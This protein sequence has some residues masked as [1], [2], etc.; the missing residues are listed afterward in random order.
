MLPERW[1]GVE[2]QK[3][4]FD[5]ENRRVQLIYRRAFEQLLVKRQESRSEGMPTEM[6]FIDMLSAEGN[7]SDD[8]ICKNN[9][10]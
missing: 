2:W 5:A 6:S 9:S 8:N 3:R 7:V 4:K 1:L 10:S